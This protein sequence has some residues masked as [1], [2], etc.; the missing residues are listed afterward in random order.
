MNYF[1]QHS[2]GRILP[3]HVS[4]EKFKPERA[5]RRIVLRDAGVKLLE[6]QKDSIFSLGSDRTG[7]FQPSSRKNLCIWRL[8]Q[9]VNKPGYFE[10]F[11]HKRLESHMAIS[12]KTVRIKV[13]GNL[14]VTGSRNLLFRVGAEGVRNREK[15]FR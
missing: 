14:K 5:L 15:E 8:H 12:P 9:E 1:R 7:Q 2:R 6:C 3:G 10:Q 4:A 11:L 13:S